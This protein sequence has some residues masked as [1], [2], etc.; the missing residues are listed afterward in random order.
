MD[1]TGTWEPGTKV[2]IVHGNREDRKKKL[3]FTGFPIVAQRLTNPTRNHEV[4]GSIPGLAQWV[5]DLA[6]LWAVV[7]VTDV[8]RILRCSG[9][10]VGLQKKCYL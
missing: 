7:K 3:L 1:S 2:V 4:V 5:K 10:G 6:L 9:C 8:V